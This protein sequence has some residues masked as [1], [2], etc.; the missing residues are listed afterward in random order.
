MHKS[1]SLVAVVTLFN[2]VPPSI[3]GSY[4][5]NLLRVTLLAPVF[6]ENLSTSALNQKD[7]L[8]N[9]IVLTTAVIYRTASSILVLFSSNVRK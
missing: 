6:L 7:G 5:W 4:E 9:R 3:S 8:S 1:L 2:T